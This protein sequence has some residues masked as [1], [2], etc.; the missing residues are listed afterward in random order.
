MSN[1]SLSIKNCFGNI[2]KPI[3]CV[4]GEF[5]TGKTFLLN[6]L[7]QARVLV[8]K[9]EATTAVITILRHIDDKPVDWP[10]EHNVFTLKKNVDLRTLDN[11]SIVNGYSLDELKILTTYPLTKNHDAVMFFLDADILKNCIFLDCPGVGA[12]ANAF[13]EEDQNSLEISEFTNVSRPAELQHMA[14]KNADAFLLLSSVASG[15]GC[16]SNFYTQ[17]IL[18]CIAENI[19]NFQK[20]ARHEN[21][22]FVGTYANPR[23]ENM[24]DGDITVA[25]LR[26]QLRRQIRNMPPPQRIKFNEMDLCKRVVLFYGLDFQQINS[27]VYVTERQL[28]R[29]LNNSSDLE[30]HE[31]AKIICSED[32]PNRE[33]TKELSGAI[34]TM[35]EQLNSSMLHEVVNGNPAKPISVM[36][37]PQE[38]P[39]P[40]TTLVVSYTAH[41]EALWRALR[42]RLEAGL[43]AHRNPAMKKLKVWTFRD[44]L[45]GQND[46]IAIQDQFGARASAGLLCVSVAACGRDY[47]RQYEWPLFRDHLGNL[48]KPFV[49]IMLS[50]IDFAQVDLGVLGRVAQGATQLL[51]LFEDK[52]IY[53]WADCLNHEKRY[54]GD[55]SFTSQ[56]VAKLVHDLEQQLFPM[57]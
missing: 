10:V 19:K 4:L 5:S 48:L 39:M 16:F 21:I 2:K 38:P 37:M 46:H 3:I 26:N 8:S 33:R 31:K 24:H 28:K 13:Y 35:I 1:K 36:T 11:N 17:R 20:N 34:F 27:E 51:H 22:L 32:R 43:K 15:A 41:D 42:P 14:I 47:I 53:S 29:F 45:G 50:P 9:I 57:P 40:P 25:I 30:I 49:A 12:M 56:F 44:L 18:N 6:W 54:A 23:M 55:T 7:M 52:K